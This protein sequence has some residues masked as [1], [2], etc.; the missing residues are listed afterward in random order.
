MFPPPPVQGLGTIGGFKLQIEDRA[1]LGYEA[2]N[3][4]TQG[5]HRQGQARR[6]ELAGRVLQLPGQRAAALRRHRPHQ[7]AAARRARDRRVRHDADLPRLALRQRLQQVRPHLLRCGVQ[8]DAPFR[9]RADDIGAAEGAL[10]HRRDGAAVGAA[11]GQADRRARSA[12][13]ATTASSPPT[14]TAAPAPGYSSGQAQ[15]AVETHRGRNACRKG[16]ALRVDRPDLP[17]N[18]RRQLGAV[19]CSR[20]RCCWCSWCSPRSTKA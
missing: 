9:A 1:G 7:G 13:C 6:R 15:A 20:W 12:P 3:D 16:I 10:R 8:A 19:W 18:P 4:A 5:V 11:E 14:S 17:G 2:L